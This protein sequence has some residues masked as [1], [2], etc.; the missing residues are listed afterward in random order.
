MNL[1]RVSI[2]CLRGRSFGRSRGV[3][4]RIARDGR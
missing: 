2:G 1:R 3:Y 4:G